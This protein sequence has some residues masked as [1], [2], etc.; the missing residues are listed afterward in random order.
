MQAMATRRVFLHIGLHKTGTTYLQQAMRHNRD[1][2]AQHGVL[3]PGGRGQ[4]NR[5][6]A[7]Y[8][9]FGRRPRGSGDERIAGQWDAMATAL[10]ATDRPAA[11][12]SEEAMSLASV[13]QARKAVHSFPDREVHVIVTARDL[14]R[15]ALSAW[16]ED[17]KTDETWTW[18]EYA[19]AL[20]DPTA[21]GKSPARGFWLRQDLPAVL[22][23]WAAV[24][25]PD[26][27]TVVTV[28]PPGA[29]STELL[30]RFGRVVGF[31]AATLDPEV[32]WHNTSLGAVGTE[33]LRRA[34][35]HL[36][37]RLNQRQ[38]HDAVET[39]L[40][41]I[42]A[43]AAGSTRLRLPDADVR[44]VRREAERMVAA[45]RTA[46]YP[47]AGDLEDLLPGPEPGGRE[48]GDATDPEL[49]QA[50]VVALAGLTEKF[51]LAKWNRRRPDTGVEADPRTRTA[52]TARSLL[53]RAKR[54][55]LNA[56]DSSRVVERGL[57][58]FLRARTAWRASRR[59]AARG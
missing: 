59:R 48:P 2:L 54:T 53:F 17:I 24:V 57:A 30:R 21:R 33:V 49:L 55:G 42:L 31:D 38:Y 29:D 37:R 13:A 18:R 56:A 34:N 6:F 7:V 27:I 50:A 46:A 41:P 16:Q 23:V 40:A 51:A 36:H 39:T 20:A 3:V 52:S 32:E 45:V 44:W 1:L 22:D 25:P 58:T 12:L 10:T 43:D 26:R 35:E 5:T 11:V 15:V 8:D 47:V 28:P 19:D 9:L 14:A 4:P